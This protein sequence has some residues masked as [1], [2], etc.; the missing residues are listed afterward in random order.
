[1]KK[2]LFLILALVS[3]SCLKEID[4]KFP[5]EQRQ[6]VLNC[7]LEEGKPI[8]ATL[9]ETVPIEDSNNPPYLNGAKITLFENGIEVDVLNVCE[10]DTF[11]NGS[12]KYNYCS[13][14]TVVSGFTYT[15]TA[16][17]LDREQVK[18]KTTIPFAA[19][20]FQ[21]VTNPENDFSAGALFFNISFKD[22]P[23]QENYYRLRV[24]LKDQ[25]RGNQYLEFENNNPFVNLYG[26]SA[27]ISLPTDNSVGIEAYITDEFFNGNTFSFD[28][29]I[30]AF[31]NIQE[32]DELVFELQSLSKSY[33]DYLITSTINRTVGDNPFAEPVRVLSNVEN[34]FGIFGSEHLSSF[35]L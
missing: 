19:E 26:S 17:Y 23:A 11:A 4:V 14:H 12:L 8:R 2:L 33:Y 5:E 29:K 21:V 10:V 9:S 34:G 27:I 32:D 31:T 18:A 28:T 20:S 16:D 13:N 3:I 15:L 6:L 7:I 1:M 22:N 35:T 30:N 25:F 24:Y